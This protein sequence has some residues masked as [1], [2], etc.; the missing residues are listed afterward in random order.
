MIAV[1]LFCFVAGILAGSVLF[2]TIM[3]ACKRTMSVRKFE[4][5]ER[6]VRSL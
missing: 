6:S 2:F 4:E 3:L 1:L 5:K